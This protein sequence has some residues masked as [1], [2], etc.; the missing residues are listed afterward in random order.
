MTQEEQLVFFVQTG[1]VLCE[2]ALSIL[3][4]TK[5]TGLLTDIFE[6][7]TVKGADVKSLDAAGQGGQGAVYFANDD[8][9]VKV[10]E[11]FKKDQVNPLDN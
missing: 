7:E 11:E 4:H 8:L 10:S 5:L 2:D 1:A 6:G 9:A 3:A